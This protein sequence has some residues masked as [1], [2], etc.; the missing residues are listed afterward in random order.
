[1]RIYKS[2]GTETGRSYTYKAVPACGGRSSPSAMSSSRTQGTRC[3]RSSTRRTPHRDTNSTWPPDY[4]AASRQPISHVHPNEDKSNRTRHTYQ[5]PRHPLS[6]FCLGGACCWYCIYSLFHRQYTASH[7]PTDGLQ[8]K[9]SIG[10][11]S[12]KE[13]TYTRW[14]VTLLGITLGRAVALGGIALRR[15]ARQREVVSQRTKDS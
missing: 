7:R 10:S 9:S 1:M 11:G 8:L 12:R 6:F 2:E 13:S 3:S 15:V 4:Y 5:A 14:R